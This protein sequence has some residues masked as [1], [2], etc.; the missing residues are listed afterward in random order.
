MSNE[1]AL[2]QREKTMARFK[3][4]FP[5]HKDDPVIWNYFKRF[6]ELGVA[7]TKVEALPETEKVEDVLK[8]FEDVLLFDIKMTLSFL[9]KQGY[10]LVKQNQK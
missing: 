8:K 10:D 9:K 4:C 3:E 6:Y 1:V 2:T 7:D 5:L